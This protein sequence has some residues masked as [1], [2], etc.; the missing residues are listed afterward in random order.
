MLARALA[1]D[2]DLETRGVMDIRGK[3]K[4]ETFFLDGRK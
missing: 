2:F 1:G 4:V 3:G